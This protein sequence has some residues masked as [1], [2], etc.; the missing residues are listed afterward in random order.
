MK[1][2][3]VPLLLVV[4]LILLAGYVGNLKK[5][6]TTVINTTP[7]K[8]WS[9][10]PLPT[11]VPSTPIATPLPPA[12]VMTL[13]AGQAITLTDGSRFISIRFDGSDQYAC[14][15]NPISNCSYHNIGEGGDYWTFSVIYSNQWSILMAEGSYDGKLHVDKGWWIVP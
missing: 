15:T 11:S 2:K 6:K 9:G 12:F 4:G 8:I 3:Y 7:T 13:N 1:K 14:I 5:L 10:T